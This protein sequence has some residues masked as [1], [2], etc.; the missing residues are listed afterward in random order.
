[1]NVL[2]EQ[3]SN[4]S[5]YDNA[6]DGPV[7][8]NEVPSVTQATHRK[9]T[10]TTLA[11][12]IQSAL[13]KVSLSPDLMMT[14]TVSPDNVLLVVKSETFTLHKNFFSAISPL[15][16]TIMNSSFAKSSKNG[17][18]KEIVDEKPGDIAIF[19]K[20]IQDKQNIN[21]NNVALLMRL[22]S[23]YVVP[24][25]T[26]ECSNYLKQLNL[27]EMSLTSVV[28][29]L[30]NCLKSVAI[31]EAFQSLI[32]RIATEDYDKISNLKLTHISAKLYGSVMA[33]HFNVM[34]MRSVESM[35]G[36]YFILEKN[37]LKYNKYIC[38]PCNKIAEVIMCQ[39]CKKEMCETHWRN[40]RCESNYGNLELAKIKANLVDMSKEF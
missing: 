9:I 31:D 21:S 15:F 14:E 13:P 32:L 30:K 12:G 36:H 35:N 40:N 26:I 10:R 34:T 37:K 8:Y 23:K 19:I 6:V 25:L 7:D 33:T 1:M 4:V 5:T 18:M 24:T 39:G 29:I 38:K 2:I 27:K 20:C 3:S 22:A 11:G 17:I 28:N 16:K